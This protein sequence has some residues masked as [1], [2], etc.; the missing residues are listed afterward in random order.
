MA[1]N[2]YLGKGWSFPPTFE[3][4]A[5]AVRMVEDEQNVKKSLQNI[6]TTK[7]GERLM[8]P[9]F[10]CALDELMFEPLNTTLI[11]F[12]KEMINTAILYFE[13]RVEVLK[14]DISEADATEGLFLINLDYKIRANNTRN[15]MVFPFY[16]NEGTIVI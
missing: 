9:K 3:K 11:T 15:N 5:D 12:I 13:P 14:I 7:P 16:K 8:H 2:G 10:G 4:K 1:N 6:L